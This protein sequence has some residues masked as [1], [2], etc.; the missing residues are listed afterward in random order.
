MKFY[1]CEGCGKRITENQIASGQA[2]DKKLR[3]V[4]CTTCAGGVSTLDTLPLSNEEAKKLLKNKSD[5][6]PAPQGPGPSVGELKRRRAGRRTSSYR[7]PKVDRESGSHSARQPTQSASS[8]VPFVVVGALIAIGVAVFLLMGGEGESDRKRVAQKKAVHESEDSKA[9]AASPSTQPKPGPRHSSGTGPKTNATTEEAHAG[10]VK[11]PRQE[12]PKEGVETPAKEEVALPLEP[13]KGTEQKKKEPKPDE[14]QPASA[15]EEKPQPSGEKKVEKP[16]KPA[17]APEAIAAVE[18]H[19]NAIRKH[20][21]PPMNLKAASDAALVMAQDPALGSELGAGKATLAV[22]KVLTDRQAARVEALKK[23][24]GKKVPLVQIGARR[25]K[26]VE[27]AEVGEAAVKIKT[28]YTINNQVK[29]RNSEIPLNRISENSWQRV[30]PPKGPD[31][32]DEWMA[33]ALMGWARGSTNEFAPAIEAAPDHPLVFYLQRERERIEMGQREFEAREMWT[34]IEKKMEEKKWKECMAEVG[35][36]VEKYWETKFRK[37]H[38]K[39]VSARML[40]LERQFST[41]VYELPHVDTKARYEDKP[42][43]GGVKLGANL[44]RRGFTLTPISNS[45]AWSTFRLDKKYRVL[46][47]WVTLSQSVVGS[48]Y[49]NYR[50]MV[51]GDG[52]KMWESPPMNLR[53]DFVFCGVDVSDVEVLKLAV[54]ADAK[55]DYCRS[56]WVEPRVIAAKVP[57][58][59]TLDVEPHP[60]PQPSRTRGVHV[61]PGLQGTYYKDPDFNEAVLRRVDEK[62]RHSWGYGSPAQEVPINNFSARWTGYLKVTEAANYLF[63]FRADNMGRVKLGG[64]WLFGS[65]GTF[66]TNHKEITTNAVQLK[67]G[68]YELQMD[69]VEKGGGSSILLTW[70]RGGRDV[71][72]LE[73]IPAERL[74]HK[75]EST[76]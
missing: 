71:D 21:K 37:D 27:I 28:S 24:I 62:T 55:A 40:E 8:I 42:K 25:A 33:P 36:F 63:G 12:P 26:P 23:L 17:R 6:E 9:L 2:R 7:L 15:T 34:K 13:E 29:T 57:L 47:C 43:V 76:K 67:E 73:D 30:L 72:K 18:R 3:G 53:T 51:I 20:L 46:K 52:R 61:K 59:P 56:S 45:T 10:G 35:I 68:T 19:L 1:F 75:P 16:P 70:L 44:S 31:T 54:K 39:K 11:T 4:Y 22:I 60:T 66:N 38:G 14:A 50:F 64:V 69:L 58:K 48:A 74:F 49:C 32:A 41:P 65:P 5:S